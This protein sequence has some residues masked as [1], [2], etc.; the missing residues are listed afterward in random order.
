MKTKRL[1][2][3][4]IESEDGARCIVLRAEDFE[5]IPTGIFLFEIHFLR[6]I[7]VVVLQIVVAGV[8]LEPTTSRL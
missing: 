8:G 2:A 4:R 1:S 6:T 7:L 3:A 5:G